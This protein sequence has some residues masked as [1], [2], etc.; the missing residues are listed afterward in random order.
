MMRLLGSKATGEILQPNVT[1]RVVSVMPAVAL[2]PVIRHRCSREQTQIDTN[3]RNSVDCFHTPILF[4]PHPS[5]VSNHTG[6]I[7]RSH[8]STSRR[9]ERKDELG[10]GRTSSGVGDVRSV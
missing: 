8:R 1:L 9:G 2:V 6:I 5:R 4:I 10:D 3:K 7:R